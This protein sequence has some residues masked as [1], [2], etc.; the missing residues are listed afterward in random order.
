MVVLWFCGNAVSLFSIL[1][2]LCKQLYQ[3][4]YSKSAKH[5]LSPLLNLIVLLSKLWFAL[6]Q[7][8]TQNG[9]NAVQHFYTLLYSGVYHCKHQHIFLGY[10]FNNYCI[11][12]YKTFIETNVYSQ[13][14]FWK[15]KMGMSV[16]EHATAVTRGGTTGAVQLKQLATDYSQQKHTT[17]AGRGRII[18]AQSKA[19]CLSCTAPVVPPLSCYYGHRHVYL[20]C[21]HRSTPTC[22]KFVLLFAPMHTNF[23]MNIII[24]PAIPQGHII[25]V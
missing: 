8:I 9:A 25:V 4:R 10:F 13:H 16:N 5:S 23:D 12:N 20:L 14:F 1:Q 15:W 11:Y 24:K 22:T 19:N 2:G 21:M 3:D 6:P 18:I 7:M 17:W